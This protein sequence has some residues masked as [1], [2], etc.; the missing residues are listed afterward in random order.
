MK[1][2]VM[3]L[4]A[5]ENA[6]RETA[7]EKTKLDWPHLLVWCCDFYQTLHHLCDFEMELNLQ[8]FFISLAS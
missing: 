4:K 3:E 1:W 7:Q 5:A 6:Q 8:Q 2:T